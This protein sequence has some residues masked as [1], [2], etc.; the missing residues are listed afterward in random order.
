M[1]RASRLFEMISVLRSRRTPGNRSVSLSSSTDGPRLE[2]SVTKGPPLCPSGI[3]LVA[4]V[5]RP[6]GALLIQHSDDLLDR[7]PCR[8]HSVRSL[9]T[10]DAAQTWREFR[11]S[12][13]AKNQ[14]S[15]DL[16]RVS[17]ADRIC[18][19]H[20]ISMDSRFRLNR[21]SI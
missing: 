15:V 21:A 14:P 18:A 16:T 4:E 7:K 19:R 12:R 13:S 8:L 1:S 5:G 20:A 6:L 17:R 2:A 3:L 11:G 10:T 9:D